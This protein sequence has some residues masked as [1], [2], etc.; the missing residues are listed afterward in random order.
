MTVKL[1]DA[2]AYQIEHLWDRF[3]AEIDKTGDGKKQ[4]IKRAKELGLVGN[5]STAAL[6]GLFL[7]NKGDPGGAIVM[8]D[9]LV[10]TNNVPGR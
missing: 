2:T 1:G 6:Q 10:K 8:A 4:F 3:Y 9:E 5:V 7:Y